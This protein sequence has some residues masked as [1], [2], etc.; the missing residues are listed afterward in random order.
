M[1]G[2]PAAQEATMAQK[3]MH[4]EAN[5]AT[6][7][8]LRTLPLLAAVLCVLLGASVL[9]G[10]ESQTRARVDATKTIDVKSG[11]VELSLKVGDIDFDYANVQIDPPSKGMVRIRLKVSGSN[12]SDHDHSVEVET[13]LVGETGVAIST[14]SKSRE[15]EEGEKDKSVSFD[16]NVTPE[17]LAAGLRFNLKLTYIP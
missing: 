6:R 8:N 15:I 13:K 9:R 4:D 5:M 17:L 14:A 10:A 16:F 11:R 12:F 2:G 3:V 1:A 7:E